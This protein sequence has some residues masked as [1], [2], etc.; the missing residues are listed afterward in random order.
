MGP[1]LYKFYFWAKIDW[2]VGGEEHTENIQE[3]MNVID[4]PDT[5]VADV[6]SSEDDEAGSEDASPRIRFNKDGALLAVSSNENGIKILANTNG[7]RLLRTFENLSYDA[8][9]RTPEA[10]KV[11]WG[12]G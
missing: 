10:P 4:M 11:R 8:A 12:V 3:E 6:E 7:L 2:N 1:D 9:S 5:D